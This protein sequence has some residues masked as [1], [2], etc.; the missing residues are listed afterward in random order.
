MTIEMCR[1]ADLEISWLRRCVGLP[2][3]GSTLGL[4][5]T[6]ASHCS[7]LLYPTSPSGI[8]FI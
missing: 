4:T 7:Q 5:S 3:D 2:N 6:I 1:R 8:Y